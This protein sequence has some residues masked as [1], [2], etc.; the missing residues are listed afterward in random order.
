M[1]DHYDI[2][3]VG[4]RTGGYGGGHGCGRARRLRTA[5]GRAAGLP[6]ARS[7]VMSAAR[8]LTIETFSA[9]TITTAANW[10]RRYRRAA[11]S[12]WPAPPSGSFRRSGEIGVSRDGI[13]RLLSA[14]QVILATGAQEPPVSSSRLD[15]AWCDDRRRRTSVAQ[16][17]RPGGARCNF[18]RNRPVALP[19]GQPVLEGRHSHPRHPRHHTPSQPV[20]RAAALAGRADEHGRPSE[21]PVAGWPSFA[22]PAFPLSSTWRI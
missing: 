12:T 6:A 2:V 1:K 13:A 11:P 19:G 16:V 5:P 21:R 20:A 22:P 18:R 17:R 9:P 7:T 4:D 3:V 14:D 10:S 8:H 15:P